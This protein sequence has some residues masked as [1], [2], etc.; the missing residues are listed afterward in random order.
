[1]KKFKV[2]WGIVI[3]GFLTFATTVASAFTLYSCSV[4]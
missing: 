3:N 2:N 4:H 1:M